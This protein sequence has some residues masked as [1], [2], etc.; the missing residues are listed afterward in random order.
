MLQ[1]ILQ[2]EQLATP[3]SSDLG[4]RRMCIKSCQA[5]AEETA[6]QSVQILQ[7]LAHSHF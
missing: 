2:A 3:Q 7:L 6:A 4:P 5:E 1:Q